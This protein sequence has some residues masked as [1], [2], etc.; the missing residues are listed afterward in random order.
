MVQPSEF[1]KLAV[2]L[3]LANFFRN[4]QAKNINK[5]RTIAGAFAII[6]PL[7]LLIAAQPDLA[8][9][10]VVLGIFV[11]M[12][13]TIGVPYRFF[14]AAGA[15]VLVLAPIAWL[16]L[17]KD[18]QK[19]RVI[20]FLFPESDPLGAGYNVIQSKIAIGS[21]GF[22]GKGFLHGT[23]SRLSFLPEHHTDFIFTIVGEEFGFIGCIAIIAIFCYLI[24]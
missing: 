1:A 16:K 19:Q 5:V 24:K 15:G 18:Y 6:S 21:G 7:L 4:V 13:F 10:I 17:L 9:S 8:T 23:Q 11:V 3:G 2:V 14:V 20:T 22:L 12:I